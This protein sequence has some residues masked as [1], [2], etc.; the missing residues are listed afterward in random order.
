MDAYFQEPSDAGNT[1]KK[2]DL[3]SLSVGGQ[4]VH[5][6]RLNIS[7]P[8]TPGGHSRVKN[9]TPD[10]TDY[11]LT[12]RQAPSGLLEAVINFSTSGD[13][14]VIAAVAGQ[15]IKIWKLWLWSADD[16]ALTIKDGAT[17]LAGAVDLAQGGQV[18]LPKD[19]DPWFT[20]STNSPFRLTTA[21]AIQLSGRVYYTQG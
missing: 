7:D 20:L 3:E 1:G 9:A 2:V 5:R 17:A 13:H 8:T 11:G 4:T 18:L 19:S 14:D 15:V 10:A 12:V 6:P 16:Q 21:Q